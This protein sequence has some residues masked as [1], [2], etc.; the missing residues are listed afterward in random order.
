MSIFTL[1]EIVIALIKKEAYKFY[2]KFNGN[3][4]VY[5]DFTKATEK[6]EIINDTIR[7]GFQVGYSERSVKNVSEIFLS[8]NDAYDDLNKGFIK[9][10]RDSKDWREQDNDIEIIFKCDF[11]KGTIR[12]KEMLFFNEFL[13][14]VDIFKFEFLPEDNQIKIEDNK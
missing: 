12:Q 7:F 3:R 13:S 14:K 11:K 10:Y 5:L 4:I 2:D 1:N 6:I 9:L 8:L